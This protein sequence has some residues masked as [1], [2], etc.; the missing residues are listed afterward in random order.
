[1]LCRSARGGRTSLSS[2]LH[3]FLRDTLHKTVV[4]EKCVLARVP[5]GVRMNMKTA[6]TTQRGIHWDSESL[7]TTHDT[8]SGRSRAAPSSAGW[9]LASLPPAPSCCWP[10][11]GGCAR[12][13][14]CVR[15]SNGESGMRAYALQ[16]GRG[17]RN[18]KKWKFGAST[19]CTR[20]SASR[21]DRG[22]RLKRG[23]AVICTLHA[24]KLFNSLH[25]NTSHTC[26]QDPQLHAYL[27]QIVGIRTPCL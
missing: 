15:F 17:A 14:I 19:S 12:V 5:V 7:T 2:T 20:T 23:R 25:A 26:V 1:M 3:I 11:V 22:D 21:S 27:D 18:H 24:P 13:S 8:S 4:T 16:L 10:S 6:D 9:S